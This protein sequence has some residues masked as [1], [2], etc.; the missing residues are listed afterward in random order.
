MAG[1]SLHHCG[2]KTEKSCD[3]DDRLLLALRD[4]GTRQAEVVQRS[5]LA[6]VCD[7]TNNWR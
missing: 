2:T 3:F 5:A 1:S 7:L 4:G 6:G